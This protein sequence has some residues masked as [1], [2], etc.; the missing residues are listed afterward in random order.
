MIITY[1]VVTAI[2][3]VI[4]LICLVCSLVWLFDEFD[5]V[6]EHIPARAALLSLLAIPGS[7]L[8]P[9]TVPIGMLV[10]IYLLAVQARIIHK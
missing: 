8:W 2:F 6:D 3:A 4:A 1:W 7:L 10:G 9:I 5:T